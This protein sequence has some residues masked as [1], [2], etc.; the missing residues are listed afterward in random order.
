MPNLV[1]QG[2][3]EAECN[4]VRRSAMKQVILNASSLV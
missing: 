1:I 4:R 2:Y 3:E